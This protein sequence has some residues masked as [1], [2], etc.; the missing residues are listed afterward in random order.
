M[1]PHPVSITT[2]R[3]VLR[4]P[5][6]ADAPALSVLMTEEV[7]RWTASWPFPL[8]EA[9]ARKK[10]QAALDAMEAGRGFTRIIT[11]REDGCPMG[12]LTIALVETTL[13]TGGL[14]YWLGTAFHRQ[15][16]LSEALMPFVQAAVAALNL[17]RLETGVQPA[18]TAS[19]AL[20]KKLGMDFIGARMHYVS[21]RDRE[22][23]T[24]FYA[25]ECSSALSPSR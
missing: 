13:R 7:S 2:A 21:A 23:M 6:L 10:L 1:G 15:G 14:G 5:M 17:A 8:P 11:R 3:L 18:N 16:Y 12:W 9:E 4:L 25:M 24:A 20:L 19:V 22:E